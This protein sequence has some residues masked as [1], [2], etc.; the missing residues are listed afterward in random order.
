MTA[1]SLLLAAAL[2]VP[3]TTWRHCNDLHGSHH[4]R[5][6]IPLAA[7]AKDELLQRWWGREDFRR[8]LAIS[9]SER[10]HIVCQ[11][12]EE[13]LRY[14]FANPYTIHERKGGGRILYYMIHASDHEDAPR[15]MD[16]SYRN[17]ALPAGAPEKIPMF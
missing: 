3:A 10:A 6:D 5:H 17:A 11:R 1:P 13:E 16:D 14:K 12:F 9:S 2:R 8:V 15:L 4:H 7:G